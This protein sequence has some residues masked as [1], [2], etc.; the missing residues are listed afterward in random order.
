MKSRVSHIW[1]SLH[2]CPV[3]CCPA[4]CC[5]AVCCSGAAVCGA[6]IN[7]FDRLQ[8][9]VEGIL[10]RLLGQS[11]GSTHGVAN[12]PGRYYCSF[13]RRLMLGLYDS[14]LG[15]LR[16]LTPPGVPGKVA[17]QISFN[18]QQ[19]IELG[20]FEYDGGNDG[21]SFTPSS[22]PIDGG[23]TV[24]VNGA[25]VGLG[26]QIKKNRAHAA[27]AQTVNSLV[28]ETAREK[29]TT[30]LEMRRRSEKVHQRHNRDQARVAEVKTS[31]IAQQRKMH[32]AEGR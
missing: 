2:H 24:T 20:T 12:G 22:G 19:F 9:V 30:F 14:G 8:I 10:F 7:C 28:Q 13:G 23:T 3:L 29:A 4:V 27:A 5:P 16:C 6:I 15:K 1:R 25:L 17:F 11:L 32:S 18:K 21:P 31:L 26:K